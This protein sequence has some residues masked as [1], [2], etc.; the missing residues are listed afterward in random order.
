MVDIDSSRIYEVLNPRDPPPWTATNGSKIMQRSKTIG[1][2]S[3]SS[4]HRTQNGFANYA[5]PR[6]L[7]MYGVLM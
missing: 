6:Y 4:G 5:V 2:A 7:Q 1:T 3:S